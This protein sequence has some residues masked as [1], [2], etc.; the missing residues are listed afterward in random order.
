MLFNL[1]YTITLG[2]EDMRRERETRESSNSRLVFF[3][4]PFYCLKLKMEKD[5]RCANNRKWSKTSPFGWWE[6]DEGESRIVETAAGKSTELWR[7][8]VLV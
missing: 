8:E 6:E 5:H 4:L 2:H 7:E 1:S 3:L